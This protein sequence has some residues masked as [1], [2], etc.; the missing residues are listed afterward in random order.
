MYAWRAMRVHCGVIPWPLPLRAAADLHVPDWVDAP[1][2]ADFDNQW[3][4]ERIERKRRL[5]EEWK[6]TAEDVA[7]RSHV[8]SSRGWIDLASLW[9]GWAMYGSA[10]WTWQKLRPPSSRPLFGCLAAGWDQLKQKLDPKLHFWHSDRLVRQ[11]DFVSSA[12]RRVYF[13]P[14]YYSR[15][16]YAGEP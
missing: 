8:L 1:H 15:D 11:L 2:S 3:S 6:Y 10:V 16:D 14:H 13:A 5:A 4:A 12:Y 9:A 7:V